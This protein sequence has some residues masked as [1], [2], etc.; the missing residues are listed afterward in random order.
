MKHIWKYYL[1]ALVV[2]GIDQAIKLAVHYNMAIGAPG[3]IKILG[4]WFKIYYT[5]NPGMAFGLKIGFKYG[6]LMLTAGRIVATILI[7]QHM[8]HLAQAAEKTPLVL[9]GWALILGGALGNVWDSVF[10]GVLLENAPA[11]TPLAWFHGQVIDMFYV[12]IWETRLPQWIPWVG[13]L[14]FSFF[15]IFNF[16]DV[17]IFL[18]IASILVFPRLSAQRTLTMVDDREHFAV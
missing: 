17:A 5:L 9:A 7:G 16:A 12:D 1:L 10:Y 3:Q 6:K 13:G 11:D 18:G 2:I 4:D 8:W 15:P 14:Y